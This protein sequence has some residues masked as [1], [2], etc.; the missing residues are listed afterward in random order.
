MTCHAP[1]RHRVPVVVGRA[2]SEGFAVE[3]RRHVQREDMLDQAKVHPL[4]YA[5]ISEERERVRREIAC[6]RSASFVGKADHARL[7]PTTPPTA[8]SV[9]T[10]PLPP[11]PPAGTRPA[12]AG[13]IA[14]PPP[15][16]AARG[17]SRRRRTPPA[18]GSGNGPRRPAPRR[19]RAPPRPPSPRRPSL[20]PRGRTAA[21]S[22]T[23]P[24][25]PR[26]GTSPP[27][28]TTL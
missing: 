27:P 7:P 28:C 26:P 20:R 9:R 13:T 2:D 1:D 3:K 24:P 4:R 23:P 21:S 16:T 15:A 12:R 6:E 10:P 25:S 14:P 18:T 22:A 11:R 19:R 17:P 5:R 8:R